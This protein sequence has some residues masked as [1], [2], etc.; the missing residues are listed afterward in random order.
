MEF[1]GR[2]AGGMALGGFCAFGGHFIV[3]GLICVCVCVCVCLGGGGGGSAG[4]GAAVFVGVLGFWG[5]L[6]FSC[7]VAH[8]GGCLLSVFRGFFVLAGVGAGLGLVLWFCG[9]S[10]TFL[11]FPNF[12]RS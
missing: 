4:C 5:R 11:V 10:G 3:H 9:S 1:E 2:V 7:G 8:F 6:W 12:L